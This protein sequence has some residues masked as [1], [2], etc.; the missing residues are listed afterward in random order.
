[1][2]REQRLEER[3]LI[4]AGGAAGAPE[5]DD[6]R[7]AAQRR[8]RERRAVQRRSGDRGDR[9]AANDRQ[10][11]SCAGSIDRRAELDQRDGRNGGEHEPDKDEPASPVELSAVIGPYW[12]FRAF[13]IASIGWI[14]QMKT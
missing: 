8:Q 13:V 7:P 5:V 6:H 11:V 10:P 12:T 4:A 14:E 9:F 2:R 1:M 3:E